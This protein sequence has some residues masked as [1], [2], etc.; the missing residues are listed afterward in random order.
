M[1]SFSSAR[2]RTP[3]ESQ[4]KSECLAVPDDAPGLALW[5]AWPAALTSGFLPGNRTS[6]AQ[7]AE[8]SEL[9]S[10][11]FQIQRKAREATAPSVGSKRVRSTCN[12]SLCFSVS[13]LASTWRLSNSLPTCASAETVCRGRAPRENGSSPPPGLPGHL[14]QERAGADAHGETALMREVRLRSC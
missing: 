10:L 9:E 13:T 6:E 14:G 5:S 8:V 12:R 11:S 1:N 7:P 4:A 3:V 2:K